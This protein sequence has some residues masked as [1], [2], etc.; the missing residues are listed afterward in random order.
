MTMMESNVLMNDMRKEKPRAKSLRTIST[1]KKVNIKKFNSSKIVLSILLFPICSS[2]AN[3][4]KMTT[5]SKMVIPRTDLST[6]G[7][8]TNRLTLV[9]ILFIRD[10][11]T[12]P[13]WIC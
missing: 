13:S 4:A 11:S 6:I 2:I 12:P 8:S 7:I 9:L 5:Q 3:S 10:I 1:M